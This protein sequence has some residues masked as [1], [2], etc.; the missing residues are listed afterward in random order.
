MRVPQSAG[1]PSWWT[2]RATAG[3]VTAGFSKEEILKP[4][5]EDP[6]A[7]NGVFARVTDL[8]RELSEGVS[9]R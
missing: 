4:V 3:E 5:A 7:E 9:L 2:T 8:L 6:R 1:P